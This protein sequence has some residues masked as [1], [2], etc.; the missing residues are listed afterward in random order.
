M[1][2]SKLL[3]FD[4]LFKKL[5]IHKF[6]CFGSHCMLSVSESP[7]HFFPSN[8]KLATWIKPKLDDRTLSPA[9]VL[10]NSKRN[11]R[12]PNFEVGVLF[13]NNFYF[14]SASS[15]HVF[16]MATCFFPNSVRSDASKHNINAESPQYHRN[17]FFS[18]FHQFEYRW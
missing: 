18:R 7:S 1:C 3:L 5:S 13:M 12:C 15:E 8:N 9:E 14:H 16:Q 17:T 10:F 2:H 11:D 6:V 4:F